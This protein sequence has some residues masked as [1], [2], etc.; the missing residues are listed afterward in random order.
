M[1]AAAYAECKPSEVTD[2]YW[3]YALR[4][5][6]KYPN[7]TVR[8][9]KWLVFVRGASV[10]NVWA[11]IKSATE[12]GKLGD[13]SKAATAKPN[14]LATNPETKVICVYTYDWTDE[15][16]VRRVREELKKLGIIR[17]IA[18]KADQD[19]LDGKYRIAGHTRI[20][21]YFE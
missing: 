1:I 20:S 21:K 18:Y 5:K 9:G 10:D 7:A 17:K 2:T 14:R 11:L 15:E 8:S 19:T 13:S 4:K 6:G 12:A 3:I 16:D